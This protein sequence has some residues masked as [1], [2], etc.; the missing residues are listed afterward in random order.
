MSFDIKGKFFALEYC[1]DKIAKRYLPA[2]EFYLACTMNRGRSVARPLCATIFASI[3]RDFYH[4]LKM[5]WTD[6]TVAEG[7]T[8]RALIVYAN[9]F[10]L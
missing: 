10:S 7:E 2:H 3:K 4:F 8:A 9:R 5:V 6:A 1:T